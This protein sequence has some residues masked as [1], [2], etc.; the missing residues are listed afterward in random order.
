[1]TCR[2]DD[3]SAGPRFALV[4]LVGVMEMRARKME[5]ALLSFLTARA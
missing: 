2:D 1:M 5:L 4:L 3:A